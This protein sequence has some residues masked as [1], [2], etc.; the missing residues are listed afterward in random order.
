MCLYVFLVMFSMCLH[1]IMCKWV[2]VCV[3]DV[4]LCILQLEKKMLYIKI[5]T[6]VCFIPNGTLVNKRCWRKELFKD[7]LEYFSI[8]CDNVDGFYIWFLFFEELNDEERRS[9]LDSRKLGSVNQ[10]TLNQET[11]NLTYNQY[12]IDLYRKNN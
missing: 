4:Y 2:C 9:F 10:N 8:E 5:L 7:L 3:C 6:C 12:A 11:Y 1:E